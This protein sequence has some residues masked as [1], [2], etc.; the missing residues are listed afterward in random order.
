MHA[1]AP[2]PE[3]PGPARLG[4]APGAVLMRRSSTSLLPLL[5][6]SLL[7]LL[8]PPPFGRAAA[9]NA[10]AAT[11]ASGALHRLLAGNKQTSGA[12]FGGGA[13]F[14]TIFS[15]ECT[16]YFDWQSLAL[17]RSHRQVRRDRFRK[18]PCR[19][20]AVKAHNDF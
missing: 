9:A 12:G 20:L 7:L 11:A 18:P 17:V 3:A 1:A 8:L 13:T 14:H 4:L 15:T 6:L 2:D 5:A 10:T 19:P 16:T